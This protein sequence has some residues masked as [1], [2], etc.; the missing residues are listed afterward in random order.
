MLSAG[1]VYTLYRAVRLAFYLYIF[2]LFVRILLT[3]TSISPYN[4]KIARFL[5]DLTDPISC[6]D[7][8]VYAAGA[9]GTAEF[10]ADRGVSD[11]ECGREHHPA[12]ALAG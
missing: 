10:F 11:P 2:I 6:E 1:L 5:S 9:P 7:R 8:A 12:P 4:S 3:W